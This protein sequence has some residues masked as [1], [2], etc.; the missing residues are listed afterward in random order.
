[1]I[2]GMLDVFPQA[3][4]IGLAEAGVGLSWAEAKSAVV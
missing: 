1:M 3:P 2:Q 4:V